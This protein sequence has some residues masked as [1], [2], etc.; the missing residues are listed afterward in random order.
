MFYMKPLYLFKPCMV[1]DLVTLDLN[2]DIK[3][4]V[5]QLKGRIFEER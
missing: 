4:L 2:L 3:Y 5:F 1:H